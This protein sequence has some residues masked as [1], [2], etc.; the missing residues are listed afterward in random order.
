M[1]N[2]RNKP[3]TE[4]L[5]RIKCGQINLQRAKHATNQITQIINER[6]LDIV[7][8]QEP[9]TRTGQVIGLG[10]THSVI[11]R[12]G[13]NPK[14]AIMVVNPQ[15]QCLFVENMSNDLFSVVQLKYNG[16]EF[17]AI[18]AYIPPVKNKDYKYDQVINEIEN[19]LRIIK[20]KGN[21]IL[22]MD[23]N[24]KSSAWGSPVN[25]PR[26]RKLQEM[27]ETNDLTI[28]NEGETPT[29]DGPC[30]TSFVDITIATP[31][32]YNK[33][34]TWHIPDVVSMS[35]HRY[36]EFII[37]AKSHN[38]NHETDTEG[39]CNKKA[40]WDVFEH[41]FKQ[42]ASRLLQDISSTST[43]ED[44]ESCAIRL[45]EFIR[46]ACREAMPPRKQHKKSV[47]WW[48]PELTK[49]RKEV[50][51]LKRKAQRTN[52][53]EE[54]EERRKEYKKEFNAYKTLLLKTR[55]EK[56]KSF[57]AENTTNDPWGAV[58]RMLRNKKPKM[59]DT[60]I[61]KRNGEYTTTIEDTHQ[62][63]LDTFF[64]DDEATRDNQ[65]HEELRRKANTAKGGPNDR[66]FTEREIRKEIKRG[67]VKKAPGEDHITADAVAHAFDC[68]PKI[69]VDMF[70]KCLEYGTFPRAWKTAKVKL[71][72]KPGKDDPSDPKSY[73]RSY[74]SK[75]RTLP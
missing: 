16:W 41:T 13:T 57:C 63:L 14:T 38:N 73:R 75:D 56:W 36:I 21:F 55:V 29:F 39:F 7:L 4:R 11:Y 6:K 1:A 10:K 70:N 17:Y 64:P 58:Y 53:E 19:K 5:D 47:P 45:T 28:L 2:N 32:M 35:D 24:A 9:H 26:G 65:E 69:F 31:D 15:I 42:R 49:K 51:G 54:R 20:Q 62:Y 3:N 18:S 66:R 34:L 30:G 44:V 59:I 46:D 25:E 50:R 33:V 43:T 61:R 27:I 60:T 72:P 67:N 71:I 40:D 48:T 22:G 68:D 74:N 37:E 8:I 12:K 23:A 52:T